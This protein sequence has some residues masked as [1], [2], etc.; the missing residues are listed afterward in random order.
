M[1]HRVTQI[2]VEPAGESPDG[3]IERYT[4]RA[5]SGAAVSVLTYGAIL[6]AARVP[7]RDGTLANVVLGFA[8]AA[9]YLTDAYRAGNPYFGA[10]AGRYANRIAGARFTLDGEEHVLEANQGPH[11]LHGGPQGFDARV[12]DARPVEGDDEAAVA[13]RLTSPDGDQGYP[14]QLAVDVVYTWTEA[15][16]L[17]IDYRAR[18]DRPTVLNL[19]NHAYF[20]LAGDGA[21]S[22]E[23]HELQVHASH[24]TPADADQLPTGEVATVEDTPL[25]FRAPRRLGDRLRDPHPQLVAARGY[26]H[27]LVLDGKRPGDGEP[28]PAAVL[29]DPA[30]GRELE[31][32]TTEPGVQ[33]YTG[34]FLDGSLVG[35]AGK[36]YRQGDGVC[37]ETQHFPNSPNVPAFP[38]T[39]LRPGEAFAS[40]T[41]LR[42]R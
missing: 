25:D 26:D 18:T 4:L 8:D 19:T 34:N 12:W 9:G 6:Q 33:L 37:L 20:N 38:S 39:V 2:D 30:S 42:F 27:N 11:Q 1:T 28:E 3:P 35:A 40:R 10:I 22:I 31:V 17:R 7:D 13:L 21:G 32:L 15:H 29:R 41:V 16:E 23:D 5:G 14:G 24:Y 36:A